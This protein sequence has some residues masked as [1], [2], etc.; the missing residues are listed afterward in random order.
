MISSFVPVIVWMFWLYKCHQKLS[1]RGGDD[2]LFLI[3]KD[4]ARDYK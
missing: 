2:L 4:G 1:N 3:L